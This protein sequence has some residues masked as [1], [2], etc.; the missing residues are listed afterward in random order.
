MRKLLLLCL[1][2]LFP[3]GSRANE[4]GK[5]P[6]SGLAWPALSPDGR[7]IAFEWLNDLWI[8]P[9]VGGEAK[10]IVKHPAREAYPQF[11]PDGKRLVF[12][13]ERSGSAQI[14]SVAVDG[15][16]L[17]MHS[18]HSEGNILEAV[19]PDGAF[20]LAR[21]ERD[22][23]GY[24]PF[25]LVKVDLKNDVRERLLFDATAHSASISSDGGRFLFCRGGEQLYRKGY[26][27][28]RASAIHLYDEEKAEFRELIAEETESRFPLW[29]ADGNGFYYVSSRSGVFNIWMREFATKNDRQLTF[30]END[31]V[32]I[33][34]ISKDGRTMVFRAGQKLY[35]FDPEGEGAP[36]EVGFFTREKV[37][38]RSVRK[39]KISGT[40]GS[41][42]SA[43]GEHVVFVGAGDL[44][45]M[46]LG[47]KQPSR[48]TETDDFDERE[49]VFSPDE[50][51]LYFLKDDGIGASLC[52][53]EWNDGKIEEVT[54]VSGAGRSK[55]ALRLSPDGRWLSWLEATGDLVTMP[56]AGGAETVV[57]KCWDMP[58]YDWSPAG[59]CLVVAARDIHANRDIWLVPPDGS[60]PPYNLTRHPA[61]E[62]SPKWSPD[63]SKI[64]FVARRN[65]DRLAKLWIAEVPENPF[66]DQVDLAEISNNVSPLDT[67][68]SEPIRIMWS[69]DSESILFQSRDPLD[70]TVY[71]LP[72]EGGEPNELAAFRGIPISSR[73]DG[74]SFWRIRR[75]PTVFR[76]GALSPFGFSFSVEQNRKA[77]LVLGFR[78]TWRT[79]KERFYDESM[80]GKDWDAVLEKYQDAAGN[81]MDSR[82]FD[83]IVAQMLG[84][85]NASHLTFK[86][87]PWGVGKSAEKTKKPT[88]HPGLVFQNNPEGALVI[89][90]VV[91]GSPISLVPDPPLAGDLVERI[92]GKKVDARTPLHRFFNGAKGSSLPLVISRK[93]GERK[94][95]ELVPIS[96]ET[97]RRLDREARVVRAE[98]K[99]SKAKQ[100]ITYL[101]FRRMKTDD[102]QELATE[103]Y[104]ASLDSKG[105]ILDL[106]DNAGGRVAD[107]LL[108]LFCQ[109]V[110]TFTEPRGGER[111]YPTDRRI[112]PSWEG[113]MVVLCN[114]NTFSNAEIFCHAFKR[115]GRGKLIGM[116]TNGGVIS[117]VSVKIPEVGD[118]QIPFRGWFHVDTGQDLELNGAVPDVIVPLLP[119]DQVREQDPQLEAA[120]RVL[121][122]ELEDR[123][124]KVKARF[125]GR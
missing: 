105:L 94:T 60:Q 10:R 69:A 101:P 14:Y 30:F 27:G 100:R 95:F 37:P 97:A 50:K 114:G 110:H 116:P 23:G 26:R 71:S 34:A 35:R 66:S 109:P 102:L 8:A 18:N 87:K 121:S 92:G 73:A 43:D 57:M 83:R 62:G 47:D 5:Q 31:G 108:A 98:K 120:L 61:F 15:G 74:S 111:G 67:E 78:R 115:L 96:Y 84:E 72:L 103:V 80:N 65:P 41:A 17:R 44:W 39:E 36:R 28:S 56:T 48:L 53:A 24:R 59:N 68:I 63:G 118:L 1:L 107:A 11:T 38:D 21:G 49:P 89:E 6:I 3:L 58:T 91:A 12:S 64:V 93:N 77:R 119:Q 46:K 32:V 22:R 52:R 19:S 25:R 45:T 51:S 99:A 2:C 33:P 81:S 85:L 75:V 54:D 55:R 20:A 104:R 90:R 42:F 123:E 70:N 122:E 88:A 112:S 16:D 86:T 13:S 4:V 82:Q 79:L 9:S 117:A 7:E 40:S 29:R 113:P 106:R 125:K 124:R 76:N